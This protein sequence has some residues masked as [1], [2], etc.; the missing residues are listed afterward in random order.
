M[1]YQLGHKSPSIKLQRFTKK[2]ITTSSINRIHHWSHHR[3]VISA[4]AAR[5]SG[6][7]HESRAQQT[8]D[9]RGFCC[10]VLTHTHKSFQIF[11]SKKHGEKFAA[12]QV[13]PIFALEPISSQADFT[14]FELFPKVALE[15]IFCQEPGAT[16]P[17]TELRAQLWAKAD[18]RR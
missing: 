1:V 3:E 4:T 15:S 2:P 14:G 18:R 13:L 10:L 17:T 9:C 16:N 12:E 5:V 6:S 11:S 8:S 7:Q